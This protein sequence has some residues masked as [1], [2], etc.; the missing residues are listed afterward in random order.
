MAL[1]HKPRKGSFVRWPDDP[2]WYEIIE[3]KD[4]GIAWM[5]CE[6]VPERDATT[7]IYKFKDGWNQLAFHCDAHG[8]P[9]TKEC[10]AR[11]LVDGWK[12]CLNI[13]HGDIHETAGG[14]IFRI[15]AGKPLPDCPYCDGGVI[16]ETGVICR[17]C[18]GRGI[19]HANH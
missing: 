17:T 5:K 19:S 9:L 16:K 1:T 11:T 13:G 2:K 14:Y 4:D 3:A 7:F 6:N 10:E 15:T 8:K 18:G 12:C